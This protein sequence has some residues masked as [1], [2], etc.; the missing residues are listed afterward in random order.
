MATPEQ[1][2]QTNSWCL[3]IESTGRVQCEFIREYGMRPLDKKEIR[4]WYEQFRRNGNVENGIPPHGLND[5]MKMWITF[6]RP[7]QKGPRNTSP[8]QVHSYRCLN[9]CQRVSSEYPWFQASAAMLMR[10]ALF[11][12]VTV[13]SGNPLPTF[14]DNVI[15]PMHSTKYTQK[16]M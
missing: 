2:A 15:Q 16:Q 6:I 5:Q 13:S 11:W 10:S 8:K 4:K 9:D 1:K 3:K 12:G 14:P 7:S